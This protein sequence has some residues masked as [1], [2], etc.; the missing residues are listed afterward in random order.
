MARKSDTQTETKE[1][2]IT[3][4]LNA[5]RELVFK[6]WTDPKNDHED[7]CKRRFCSIT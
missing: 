3:R 6:T 7:N 4:I 1:L 2:I 5:R